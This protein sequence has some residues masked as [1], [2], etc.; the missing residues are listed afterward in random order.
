MIIKNDFTADID[1]L[2]HKD[3]QRGTRT[4]WCSKI[5]NISMD[6]DV[7]LCPCISVLVMHFF[8]CIFGGKF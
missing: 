4:I 8:L 7:K 1:N 5:A 3:T 6:I 2:R